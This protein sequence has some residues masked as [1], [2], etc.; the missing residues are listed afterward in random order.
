MADLI[1]ETRQVSPA[2]LDTYRRAYEKILFNANKQGNFNYIHDTHQ[3]EVL[4]TILGYLNEKNK[5]TVRQMLS[6]AYLVKLMHDQPCN[7][8]QNSMNEI[9]HEYRKNA[10]A[11]N[12][13]KRD[14]EYPTQEELETWINALENPVA[15][16]VNSLIYK[17]GL[18][19]KDINL[20]LYAE[21]DADIVP[22]DNYVQLTRDGK[23]HMYI[24]NYKTCKTYGPKSIIIDE[25]KIIDNLRTLI[26]LR[27]MKYL[28]PKRQA[29]TQYEKCQKGDKGLDSSLFYKIKKFLYPGLTESDYFK[30]R[31][32]KS[33]KGMS[34]LSELSETRGTCIE[35]IV[36]IYG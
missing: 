14:E 10:P 24:E 3:D 36:G 34:E 26:N 11:E 16:V 2:T 22:L 33:V 23:A 20:T 9:Q 5:H 19:N 25:P 28:F 7:K 13:R 8:L 29:A 12:K 6:V 17:Y 30:I 1:F 32:I 35:T 4:D 31:I 27:K 21:E 15:Y 18:R